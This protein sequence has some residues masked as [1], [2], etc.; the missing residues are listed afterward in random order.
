[1][2]KLWNETI[3][4][5]RSAVREA[6][7]DAAWSLV[8]E[9]GLTGVTM[10][11]IASKAGIG[12]AT[13]YKYFA[14]AEAILTAWHERHVRAHLVHLR[15]LCER[16]GAPEARLEAVLEAFGL[17]LH[18]QGKHD[19]Q[20]LS[21]L[22]QGQHVDQAQQQLAALLRG[23]LVE[24]ASAGRLRSDVPPDELAGFCLDSLAGAARL[25]SAAAV[26]RL[27]TVILS[28]LRCPG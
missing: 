17:I 22:H 25:E 21:L 15:E 13:L 6:I 3:E 23:L 27:V 20:L 26:R 11:A 14:D 5:H 16:P 1:M 12:R 2:P 9:R 19:A 7:L 4:G 28:G 24:V 8:A 18:R 10:S